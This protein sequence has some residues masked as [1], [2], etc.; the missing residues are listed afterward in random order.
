[1]SQNRE[2]YIISLVDK[3]VQSGLKDIAKTV[4]E[5]RGKMGGLEQAIGRGNNG[6]SGGFSSLTKL[7]MRFGAVAGVGIMAKKVVTL[8]ADMEQ[9]RVAFA[10]FMGDTEKAN[11]LI[12][13]L[14]EFAN[15]TPFNN[16]EVIK[17]GKLL[18]SAGMSADNIS[19]SLKTLGDIASG[20]AMP[21]DDLSQIY[22]KAMNKG[23]LQAEELNQISE[24]GIPL[25]A[26]LSRMTGK[27]TA[28]IYK[29]AES[30][31]I[32]SDVLTQAF[33][34]MTSEGGTYFNLMDRQSKTLGGRF[35]TLIGQLQTIGIA[36]GEALIPVLSKMT[37][38]ALKIVENKKL[39]KDIAITVGILTGGF[40]A[41]KI[42]V[43][44][45]TL[46]TGGFST[47][48]A[49]LN[50]VMYANPIGVIIG[51]IALL[52]AG[53]VLIIRHWNEW[54]D[55]IFSFIDVILFLTGP[56]GFVIT[57][58]KKIYNSWEKIKE[59]FSTG[60]IIGAIKEIGRVI[61]DAILDP[62]QKVAEFFGLDTVSK[63]I[64]NL[65]KKAGIVTQE[66][67][68]KKATNEKLAKTVE[69]VPKVEKVRTKRTADGTYKIDAKG[70]TKKGS[71]IKSGLSEI[72][73]GA[74]KTFN[75]NI[76]SLVKEQ[77]FETVKDMADISTIVKNEVS[78][79]LF[80]VVND[81]QTT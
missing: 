68:T 39:L 46:F 77:N 74:P 24:R 79:I 14:N 31:S 7:A 67:K 25:L 4:E 59:S 19:T 55:T 41:Y 15:F 18:L 58:F 49:V 28:E 56:I 63:G 73:A 54:K 21:L 51:A 2:E 44:V 22:S 38:F 20:V 70:K 37:E 72:K 29:L 9:T 3:G 47:A 42:A 10:T 75:I 43:G 57:L 76:G 17:S 32:T 65:R 30:G 50:A 69:S 62:L 71:N 12:A 66:K 52:T 5:V 1:M 8:G 80:G 16:E 6:V 53:V 26:E 81:V 23:K 40:V 33:T 78:R 36:I 34:N 60:G 11:G 45:A 27:S 35:S 13:K 61:I 64:E 48:F